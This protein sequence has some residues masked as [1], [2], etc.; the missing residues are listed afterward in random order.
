MK[1][2]SQ[3]KSSECMC[4]FSTVGE[5]HNTSVSIALL[6][7]TKK[8]VCLQGMRRK[9]QAHLSSCGSLLF[10]KSFSFLINLFPERIRQQYFRISLRELCWPSTFAG[11]A[12]KLAQSSRGGQ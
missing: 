11:R 6:K 5:T 3:G 8:L 12:V 4:I 10:R 1:F 2:S 9:E 7:T